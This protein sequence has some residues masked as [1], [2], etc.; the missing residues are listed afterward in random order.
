M[1]WLQKRPVAVGPLAVPIS[2]VTLRRF[3]FQL[4]R[5]RRRFYDSR[6]TSGDIQYTGD[7][8]NSYLDDNAEVLITSEPHL[9]RLC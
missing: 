5:S 9:L 3:Q 4:C 7:D 2:D 1:Q 6:P 8:T